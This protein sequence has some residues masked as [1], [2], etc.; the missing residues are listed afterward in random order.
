M[1]TIKDLAKRLN[2]SY[3]TVSKSLN[4][5]PNVSEKTRLRVLAEAEKI[6]FVFN[7]NARGLAKQK[8][9]RIGILVANQFNTK[10][11]QWFFGNIQSISTKA[12]EESGYDFFIQPHNTIHGESNIFR[13]VNGKTVDGIII[14]SR[15]VTR[16]EYDFLAEKKFPHVYC[17]YNP[18]FMN[19]RDLNLFLD[20]DEYGGYIATKHLIKY[21]H[22][23]I[24]AI[25]A[26]DPA[27]KMYTARTEGYLRA[28]REVG[29]TPTI[30]EIPMTFS[31]ARQ[32]V[33]ERLNFLR[34]FTAFFVEQDKVAISMIN[35]FSKYG[36]SLG[37]DYGMIGYNNM[38]LIEDL[39]IPLTSVEDPMDKVINSGVTALVSIIE[40]KSEDCTRLFYPKLIERGSV[41]KIENP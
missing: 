38:D 17:Y 9:Q 8:T 25:K 18:T 39:A 6:G 36:L 41:L 14:F 4:N 26:E 31:A 3:S 1:A 7:A 27:M 28:T 29:I 34:N 12:V 2:V 33:Q 35:E 32:L 15:T 22:R 30:V 23:Q 19:E 11:Y 13:M 16:E 40:K 21:G 5:D 20:D 24:L 37:R 10:D